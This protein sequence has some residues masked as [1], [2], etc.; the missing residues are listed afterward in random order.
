M[1]RWGRGISIRKMQLYKLKRTKTP[2][3]KAPKTARVVGNF[4]KLIENGHV[5]APKHTTFN[6]LKNAV[7]TFGKFQ[8]NSVFRPIQFI[9]S[10]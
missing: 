8:G 2:K 3:R 7:A 6:S 9:K 1:C 5:I 4:V 10:E